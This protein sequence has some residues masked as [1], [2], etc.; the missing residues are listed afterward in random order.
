M[1]AKVCKKPEL[2]F[3]SMIL[4]IN[5]KHCSAAQSYPNLCDPQTAVHPGFPDASPQIFIYLESQDF[6][7]FEKNS[8][9]VPPRKEEKTSRNECHNLLDRDR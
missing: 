2:S 3:S 5:T 4:S 7:S 1:E 9:S 8:M 6:M